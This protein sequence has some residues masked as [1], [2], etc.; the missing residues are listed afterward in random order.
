MPRRSTSARR[1]ADAAAW[2]AESHN[3]LSSTVESSRILTSNTSGVI[4]IA[5][6][7]A[8]NT[9]PRSGNPASWRVGVR[10]AIAPSSPGRQESGSVTTCS[11]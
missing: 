9:K 2:P 7:K 6:L 8:Q 11:Q 1:L 5:W 4:L 10:S 3:T